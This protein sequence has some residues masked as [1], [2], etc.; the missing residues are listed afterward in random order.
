[1]VFTCNPCKP[2]GPR[3]PFLEDPNHVKNFRSKLYFKYF[4]NT[5]A[6]GVPFSPAIPRKPIPRIFYLWYLNDKWGEKNFSYLVHLVR[7]YLHV[8][9]ERHSV[10][11]IL[12]MLI[13][14]MFSRIEYH[15][16]VFLLLL[17]LFA[18][19]SLVRTSD[20]SD[21]IRYVPW[22][23]RSPIRPTNRTKSIIIKVWTILFLYTNSSYYQKIFSIYI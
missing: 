10:L 13:I 1:M 8:R 4:H 6:P 2:C 3:S 14:S 17:I 22:A 18:R 7:L 21:C 19:T 11:E 20:R 5:C 12:N 23:P 9:Q 15:A 16:C